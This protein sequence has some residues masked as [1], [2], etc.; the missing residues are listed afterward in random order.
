VQ[1]D[2]T[3]PHPEQIAGAQIAA[4]RKKLI[5]AFLPQLWRI[6]SFKMSSS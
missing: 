3:R 5:V 6:N 2:A 4:S 1:F